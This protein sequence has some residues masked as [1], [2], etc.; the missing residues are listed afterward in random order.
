MDHGPYYVE[1]GQYV[2]P[3]MQGRLVIEKI[4]QQPTDKQSR[5]ELCH[6]T[7]KARV[8]QVVVPFRWGALD[9]PFK[10]VQQTFCRVI[11]AH[12]YDGNRN[13]DYRV[14]DNILIMTRY[15]LGKQ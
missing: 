10:K 5:R 1:R 3:V 8:Q 13:Q 2:G 11:T 12:S 14:N 4:R 7:E 15:V 9:N 6:A